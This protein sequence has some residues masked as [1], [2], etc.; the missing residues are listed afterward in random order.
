M[1]FRAQ[2]IAKSDPGAAAAFE[3]GLEDIEAALATRVGDDVALADE[4]RAVRAELC[5][6]QGFTKEE[7]R[8]CEAFM[9]KSCH[10]DPAR[11]E[12]SGELASE[13][14]LSQQ[15][16]AAPTAPPLPVHLCSVYFQHEAD[17]HEV[18]AAAPAA[19]VPLAPASAPDPA[20]PAPAPCPEAPAWTAKI[21][22][23]LPEQGLSGPF[24]EHDDADT[25][26]SDWQR[27]FGPRSGQ[28]SLR[29]ICMDY[30]DNAWCKF[31]MRRLRE[32]RQRSRAAGASRTGL[33]LAVAVLGLLTV[34]DR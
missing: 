29:R 11:E 26:T 33:A 15:R 3:A 34:G 16:D 20:S 4:I 19:A 8:D 2:A 14:R 9:R 27:E 1:A 5:T 17:A 24:V 18:A 31:Q 30:P 10:M 12:V 28:R 13:A 23:E 25:Q 6:R 7:H 32:L 21:E 22:G